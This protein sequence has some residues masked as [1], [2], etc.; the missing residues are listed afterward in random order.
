VGA[1]AMV[2]P[3]AAL[4]LDEVRFPD[5]DRSYS[6]SH[7]VEFYRLS[8]GEL[9]AVHARIDHDGVFVV[10]GH[11]YYKVAT[12]LGSESL[13][14][15]FDGD[16][17]SQVRAEAQARVG[18]RILDV[19]ALMQS[20]ANDVLVWQWHLF[21]FGTRLSGG[22]TIQFED[23]IRSFFRSQMR[24]SGEPSLF[25]VESFGF[26]D[27]RI[28]C[29]FRVLVPPSDQSWYASYLSLL[30]QLDRDIAEIETFRGHY[31]HRRLSNT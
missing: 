16:T 1:F 17:D 19:P 28:R 7:L 22:Q 6:L 15:I 29:Q 8:Q 12:V 13:R 21:F 5:R 25:E 3:L 20:E 2:V 30:R 14:V 18:G 31:F 10:R 26:D 27:A 23:K 11:K 4:K 9:P 24:A